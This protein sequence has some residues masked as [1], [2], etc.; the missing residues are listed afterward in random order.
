MI[1]LFLYDRQTR[2][3]KKK[4]GR[5]ECITTIYFLFVCFFSGSL[6]AS[7]SEYSQ[8]SHRLEM[9]MK[10]PLVKTA[11]KLERLEFIQVLDLLEVCALAIQRGSSAVRSAQKVALLFRTFSAVY[12]WCQ[13]RLTLRYS[14]SRYFCDLLH[15]CFREIWL[16]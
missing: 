15:F 3:Y 10:V 4:K 13:H 14:R 5:E 1:N 11:E 9:C 8:D 2:E 16:R 12:P 7:S 6:S